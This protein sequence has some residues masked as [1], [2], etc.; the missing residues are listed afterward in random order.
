[1]GD[2]QGIYASLSD[3]GRCDLN[4]RRRFYVERVSV[5]ADVGSNDIQPETTAKLSGE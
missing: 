1:M 2:H 4:I 3:C 5:S